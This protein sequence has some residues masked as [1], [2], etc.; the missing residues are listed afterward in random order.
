MSAMSTDKRLIA[1]AAALLDSRGESNVTLRAVGAAVGMS[2][3]APYKHFKDRSALL[4]AVAIDDFTMLTKVFSKIRQTLLKALIKL[5]RALRA[6]IEFGQKYPGRYR[7]PFSSPNIAPPGGNLER[8]AF[9]SF[10]EFAGIVREAQFSKDLPDIPNVALTGLL[11]ASVHGL[12]DLE[13]GG[14]IRKEKGLSSATE[15]MA[16]LID[17]F[18]REGAK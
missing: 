1:A 2:H 14:L 8:V 9:Q 16:L 18:S 7:L 6:F 11:F 10:L 12:I 3:N 15:T 13:A 5:Q 17:L 4:A